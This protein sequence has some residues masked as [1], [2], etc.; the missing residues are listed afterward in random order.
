MRSDKRTAVIIFA[1]AFTGIL[2]HGRTSP[3]DEAS[4]S[5]TLTLKDVQGYLKKLRKANLKDCFV[6]LYDKKPFSR[7]VKSLGRMPKPDRWKIFSGRVRAIQNSTKQDLYYF[8]KGMKVEVLGGKQWLAGKDLIV[9]LKNFCRVLKQK[10]GK[11]LEGI[12]I[13]ARQIHVPDIKAFMAEA[14]V[15]FNR[16]KIKR[17]NPPEAIE[18]LEAKVLGGEKKKKSTTRTKS[19]AGS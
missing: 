10:P 9:Q 11:E 15:V 1:L 19:T 2:A 13:S 3:A 4:S 6:T 16:A 14:E 8:K 12:N 18:Y 7:K 5:S 17:I